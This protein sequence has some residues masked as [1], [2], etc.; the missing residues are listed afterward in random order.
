[1]AVRGFLCR[2]L[3]MMSWSGT[4][5]SP[6]WVAGAVPEL[7]ELQAGVVVQQHAAAVIAE[8]G[9]AGVRADVAGRWSAGRDGFAFGQEQRSARTRSAAGQ[10]Q[11]AREQA[12]GAGVPVHP[13]AS[14]PGQIIELRLPAAWR[15]S[16]REPDAQGTRVP[17]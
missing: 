17:P 9:P 4:L 13:L 6:R 2:D 16:W 1:M 7:V 10:A 3:A 12:G 15:S 14:I 5:A 8:A 11:Q